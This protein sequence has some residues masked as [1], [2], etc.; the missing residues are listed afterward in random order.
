MERLDD[1]TRLLGDT[2][3]SL[4]ALAGSRGT[5]PRLKDTLL[6]AA[7]ACRMSAREIEAHRRDRPQPGQP[8]IRL[9]A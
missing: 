4:E 2:A 9:R 8:V 3:Q 5:A 1:I 6:L 7:D